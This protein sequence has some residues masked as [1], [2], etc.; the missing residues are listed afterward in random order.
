[1]K[2]KINYISKSEGHTGF[3]AK[4]IN[5]KINSV[6][7]D[8]KEGAR[9]IEG[10]LRGRKIEEAPII[11]SRICGICPVV[12]NLASIK[13]IES[14]LDLKIPGQIINLRKLMQYG[15][16]IQSHILHIFFLAIS[17]YFGLENSLDLSKK[18]SKQFDD[19]IKIRNFA[20]KIVEVIG[21]RATHPISSVIGGFIKVPDKIKLKKILNEQSEI[22]EISLKILNLFKEIKFP[23]FERKTEFIALKNKKKYSIYDGNITSNKGLNIS[24]EK[25]ISEFEKFQRHY[26]V[27]NL[28]KHNK[29]SFMVGALARLNLSSNQLN[30]EAKN[31]LKKI[32][33]TLPNNNIFYNIPAQMIEV[34]H[35]IE[36]SKKI[37]E[38]ILNGNLKK[39]KIDYQIKTGEGI[40]AIEAPRGIL[41]HFYKIDNNGRIIKANIITPTAQFLFNL[42]KDLEKY[43]PSL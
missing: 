30:K 1:M 27:V 14:A 22:L 29:D 17:D 8:I 34:I 16:I 18:Y 36:E 42:E 24:I 37:L 39:C 10:I 40:G 11:T 26:E 5:G 13:A 35:L 43:I 38:K 9:L 19:V 41:L 3:E 28:V 20:N 4:I 21:G 6:R 33:F 31:S 25:Y 12:H 15:Q 7:M 32:K 2:I 23:K